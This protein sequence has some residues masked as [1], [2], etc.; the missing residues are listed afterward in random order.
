MCTPA[1]AF[2]T[3]GTSPTILKR[4]AE[5]MVVKVVMKRRLRRQSKR[6]RA[7]RAGQ[8]TPRRSH[9][10]LLHTSAPPSLSLL[11]EPATPRAQAG[12]E[13]ARAPPS[14]GAARGAWSPPSRFPPNG[15]RQTFLPLQTPG[16]RSQES[17]CL[18]T[19][20]VGGRTERDLRKEC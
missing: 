20:K 8:L 12:G 4:N 15:T 17:G 7:W 9:S 2:S 11:A 14:Q 1:S 19:G 16:S 6:L 13:R 18:G 3:P 5:T 10:A